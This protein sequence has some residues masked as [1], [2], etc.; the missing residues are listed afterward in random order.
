MGLLGMASDK[1][2]DSFPILQPKWYK[3]NLKRA[4][5]GWASGCHG[6]ERKGCMGGCAALCGVSP[7]AVSIAL[8]SY[9]AGRT[10]GH[11]RNHC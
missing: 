8:S 7:S 1:Q 11:L 4:G 5:G 9:M 6:A 2:R 10:Q 3:N